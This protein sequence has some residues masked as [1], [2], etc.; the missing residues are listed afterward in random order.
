MDKIKVVIAD[1]NER[2]LQLLED[3]LNGDDDIEVVG[4]AKNGEEAI[5]EIINKKP[6]VA[7]IDII[8]PK[9]D[10]LAVMDKINNQEMDEKPIFIV[11]SAIGRETITDD[12]FE[13]GAHYYIM[14]PFDNEVVLN[15]VKN[16]KNTVKRKSIEPRKINAFENQK[17]YIERNL[18]A[19]VT[20]IIH[21]IGVPAHIKGYTFLRD[22]IIMSIND[23]EML[24]CVTKVLYP[25]I[26]KKNNTTSSR[27]ERAIRHAIEVA[28]SRGEIETIDKIFGFTV[29]K[30]KGKPTNSEF[31]A[32]ISDKIRLEYKC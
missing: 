10:G 7:L 31:I 24:N 14:K 13:L 20:S 26:A 8:M 6:D 27:V 30:G 15:R 19:D 4:K 16:V 3:V 29:N 12:A 1:D 32:L 5:N 18:E 28:W 17:E 9:Y 23:M 22:A 11:L 25:A 21:D 2:I